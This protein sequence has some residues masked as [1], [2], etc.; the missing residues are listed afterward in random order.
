M[1][2]N[3]LK[4]PSAFM[5]FCLNED[6]RAEKFQCFSFNVQN[7]L[8]TRSY[9]SMQCAAYIMHSFEEL[10]GLYILKR[11]VCSV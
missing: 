10:V 4:L 11:Y 6:Y 9:D 1:V 5:G 7:L 3:Q 8:S 2:F